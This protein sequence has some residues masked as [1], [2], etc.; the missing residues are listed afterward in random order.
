MQ[1]DVSNSAN[2]V[3]PQSIQTIYDSNTLNINNCL[4]AV[5]KQSMFINVEV[6]YLEQDVYG[7]N[8]IPRVKITF[9]NNKINDVKYTTNVSKKSFTEL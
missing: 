7:G 1:N 9:S 2:V 3:S 4:S 8:I 5:K 6:I